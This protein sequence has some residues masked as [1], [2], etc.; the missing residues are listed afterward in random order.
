MVYLN[1][2]ESAS[3]SLEAM[4]TAEGGAVALDLVK[5]STQQMASRLSQSGIGRPAI[6]CVRKKP[7]RNAVNRGDWDSGCD[8]IQLE[9]VVECLSADTEQLG[10]FE[11]VSACLLKDLDDL[12]SLGLFHQG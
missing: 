2:C 1:K 5:T 12:G 9:L 11:L 4:K 8:L 6:Y 3:R 10:G 7:V